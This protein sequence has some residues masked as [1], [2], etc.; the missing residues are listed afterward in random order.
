[1]FGQLGDADLKSMRT[2]YTIVKCGGFSPAQVE[3]GV[4]AATISTQMSQLE[5]RMGMRLCHRGQAGFRLTEE[6]EK[7]YRSCERLFAS[8]EN[9]K[10]EIAQTSDVVAGELRV[11]LINHSLTHPDLKITEALAEFNSQAP[12]VH[13]SLY[14]GLETEV[15]KRVID[16]RLHAGITIMREKLQQLD[17]RELAPED[18]VLYCA[19]NH[20][21]F[22]VSDSELSL[23]H[24]SE[25]PYVSGE[26][27]ERLNEFN[28]RF[29][30][31]VGAGTPEFEGIARLILT[32]C[33][34]G[35]LPTHYAEQWVVS[36]QMRALRPR[37]TRWSATIVQITQK[38]TEKP[39]ILD[40]FLKCL[41]NQCPG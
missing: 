22:N 6:G 26:Y 18:F 37:E 34:I 33:Y 13:I 8:I 4:S 20:P 38:S 35:Y 16:G 17:Y 15:E 28:K 39:R 3:L 32:G 1:M 30:G 12:E 11:G 2:F 10:N 41:D 40:I 7:V 27:W 14:V 31:R 9:F 24:L 36:G 25:Y 21:L 23:S 5:V 19:R 29:T